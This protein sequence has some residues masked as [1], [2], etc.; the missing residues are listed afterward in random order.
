VCWGHR[1]PYG[2]TRPE[3]AAPEPQ[4]G[5]KLPALNALSEI[6]RSLSSDGD[7]EDLL[8]RFLSTMI[9]LAGAIVGAVRV[10]APDGAHLRLVGSIGLPQKSCSANSTYPTSAVFAATLPASRQYSRRTGPQGKHD[11]PDWVALARPNQTVVVY[12][13]VGTLGTT[14]RRLIEHGRAAE[15]PAAIIERATA[16]DQRVVTGTLATLPDLAK[17]R[18][19]KPPALLI[20]G[21]V[22]ALHERL[23][24]FDPAGSAAPANPYG[25]TPREAAI[26]ADSY[27][28]TST[29]LPSGSR[30]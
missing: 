9:R 19:V 29:R 17:A 2:S 10:T 30:K 8:A 24:W 23:A 25:L 26:Q 3:G 1:P 6:T 15:T 12:M 14:A 20:I 21:E 18:A 7:V 16:P 11:E 28:A 13:G 22:V 4:E 5:Y 27:S